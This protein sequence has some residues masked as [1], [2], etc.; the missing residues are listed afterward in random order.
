MR[1]V[2]DNG[3]YHLRNLGDVAMLQVCL[4]R[5]ARL[6]PGA[7]FHVL[8]NAPDLLARF[9][10]VAHAVSPLG[11]DRWYNAGI[12]LGP[13]KR[14]LPAR[15]RMWAF[16]A[17]QWLKHTSPRLATRWRL[18]RDK[19]SGGDGAVTREMA[20]FV[21]L[22][23]GA[24]LV[25]AS[26]GGYVTDAFEPQAARVLAT[27][28]L[29]S[30]LGTPTAMFSQGLGPVD[31]SSLRHAMRVGLRGATVVGVRETRR[32]VDLL[33]DIAVPHG[34]IHAT[35][36]DAIELAVPHAPASLGTH[37]GFNIRNSLGTAA[38][39]DKC[40]AI[41]AAVTRLARAQGAHIVPI[42]ISFHGRESDLPNTEWTLGQ[43]GGHALLADSR[44]VLDPIDVVRRAG[45][46]RVVLTCSY[47]AAV[48]ALA[49]GVPAVC[50]AQSRYYEDKFLGMFEQFR[51]E[52]LVVNTEIAGWQSPLDGMLRRAWAAA[53]D[54]VRPALLTAAT[55]QVRRGIGAYEVVARAAVEHHQRRALAAPS[56]A[57]AMTPA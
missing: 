47:H 44:E 17:E 9:C 24:D 13:L 5:L 2:V 18:L 29:A 7:Q 28:R 46:C 8:T 55:D 53:A 21:D 45:S 43:A 52:P 16:D 31:S 34:A 23:A 14:R 33:R 54:G 11:R 30:A 37:L 1:V 36:D 10:P 38:A 15:A 3:S 41:A 50:V 35:G 51:A 57:A 49:Q 48:F 27:L 4:G 42:P 39:T 25:V 12:A 22:V 32:A 40:I 6:L 20:D 26:G 56:G 19:P